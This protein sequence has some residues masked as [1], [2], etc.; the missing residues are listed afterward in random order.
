M[1]QAAVADEEV[2]AGKE[3][4]AHHV[5]LISEILQVLLCAQVVKTKCSRFMALGVVATVT[6]DDFVA[7]FD[8]LKAD[9]PTR[10]HDMSLR[11]W[12]EVAHQ[13]HQGCLAT[14]YGTGE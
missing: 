4:F 1:G 13:M 9:L 8:E 5:T 2:V 6:L 12:S 11:G 10:L 3:D 7:V 14:A